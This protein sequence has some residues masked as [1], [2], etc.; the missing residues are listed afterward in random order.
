MKKPK[1]RKKILDQFLLTDRF[2][3]PIETITEYARDAAKRRAEIAGWYDLS[4]R[5]LEQKTV[6]NEKHY[7]F[8]LCGREYDFTKS[9]RD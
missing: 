8:L 3:L 1:P 4:V 5:L 7:S 2:D 9:T 6:H